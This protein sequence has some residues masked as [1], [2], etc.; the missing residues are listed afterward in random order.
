ML[1]LLVTLDAYGLVA[2]YINKS[3]PSTL[4]S[5]LELESDFDLGVEGMRITAEFPETLSAEPGFVPTFSAASCESEAVIITTL[6]DVFIETKVSSDVTAVPDSVLCFEGGFIL[7]LFDGDSEL[8]LGLETDLALNLPTEPGMLPLSGSDML[9]RLPLFTKL[10]FEA[11]F[12]G[13]DTLLSP[14]F[15]FLAI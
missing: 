3:A 14:S 5:L 13:E 2:R 11:F 1:V 12:L 6:L 10:I 9:P 8:W 7:D 4:I 15:S